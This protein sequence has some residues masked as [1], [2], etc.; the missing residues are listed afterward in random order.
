MIEEL[1]AEEYQR[2]RYLLENISGIK[3]GTGKEYLV[4]SRLRRLLEKESF[5]SF[6]EL[7]VVMKLSRRVQEKVIDAMTVNETLWFRDEEP[8]RVFRETL[9]PEMA[10]LN[11]P[12]RVWSAACSTGQEPYSLSME[13]EE[14]KKQFPGKLMAGERILA[15]DISPTSLAIAKEGVYQ[16]LSI[17]RGMNEDYLKSYFDKDDRGH[18]RIKE[19]IKSRVEFRSQ[20]LQQ[21]YALLGKF[22]IIFCRNV[23]I[24]FSADLKQDILTRM[25]ACLNPG[26]YLMLGSSEIMNNLSAF[27]ETVKCRSTVVYKAKKLGA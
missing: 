21:S 12:L 1:T 25:H 10:E 23:L 15:T 26:G 3:L 6:S 19:S 27:Y 8:Y 18:W 9:L 14:Y 13:I 2:F 4:R 11:R 5:G 20:N 22:D 16:Q 24:Y 17:Q 7:M